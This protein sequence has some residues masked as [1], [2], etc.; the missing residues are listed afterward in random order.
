MLFRSKADRGLSA[1][2]VGQNFVANAVYSLPSAGSGFVSALLG[3]WQVAGVFSAAGGQ[4]FSPSITGYNAP[5]LARTAGRQRPDLANG[6]VAADIT[7]PGNP[8]QYFDPTAFLLAPPGFY[9]NAGRNI[10]IGPGLI[11]FDFSLDKNIRLHLSE[12]SGL[13]FR[14]DFFNIFNHPNFGKPATDVLNATSRLPIASA[15]LITST[16]NAAR[17]MQ[18]SLK[19]FF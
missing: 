4:P 19:L 18:F 14:A 2:H 17:Q 3:G 6:R 16:S 5:D 1:L 9:G 13:E 8:G 12:A 7:H 11:D 15:G 10:M